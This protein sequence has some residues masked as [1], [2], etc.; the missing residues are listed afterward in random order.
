MRK[1]KLEG[2][3]GEE[4]EKKN[5]GKGKILYVSRLVMV[6]VGKVVSK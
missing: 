6:V 1:W 2:K 5:R 3:E 4:E